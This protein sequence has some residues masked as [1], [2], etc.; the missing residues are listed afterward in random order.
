VAWAELEWNRPSRTD[1]YLMRVAAEVVRTRV[2]NPERVTLD[3]MRLVWGED[4]GAGDDWKARRDQ[5]I[6]VV[7]GKN[8]RHR[9]VPAG[10]VPKRPDHKPP[11]A[12]RKDKGEEPK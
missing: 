12:Y 9:K 10:K 11:P 2:K 1:H 6:A 8:V 7:G 3:D 5:T 4:A